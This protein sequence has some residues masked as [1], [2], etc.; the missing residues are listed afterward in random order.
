MTEY[1][2]EPG[3]VKIHSLPFPVAP[4]DNGRQRGNDMD[5]RKQELLSLWEEFLEISN[6]RNKY[7]EECYE[8]HLSA[9][10]NFHVYTRR[11]DLQDDDEL[12]ILR[13]FDISWD[14]ARKDWNKR[15]FVQGEEATAILNKLNQTED[16]LMETIAKNQETIEK[17]LEALQCS[18]ND[19]KEA[20]EFLREGKKK[21]AETIETK[22]K[23]K[24]LFLDTLTALHK[25]EKIS[26]ENQ[27]PPREFVREYFKILLQ[28]LKENGFLI[29]MFMFCD[30][31]DDEFSS[32]VKGTI[33]AYQDKI[34][35]DRV[36]G[37]TKPI[38]PLLRQ[39][40]RPADLQLYLSIVSEKRKKPAI[41]ILELIDL[42]GKAK[43]K[44]EV[45]EL[46]KVRNDLKS[47][48]GTAVTH[49]KQRRADLEISLLTVKRAFRRHIKTANN[50][51][52]YVEF[53]VFPMIPKS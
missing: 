52:R 5:D 32:E 2:S 29:L 44:K 7:G 33:K 36:N 13:I 39:G 12:S 28:S 18:K 43:E 3:D 23:A 26:P 11:F 48:T 14:M 34:I 22:N 50:I 6:Y 38:L 15:E 4:V 49:L 47:A 37:R 40:G 1:G 51:L 46:R 53:G 42:F 35:E 30:Y 25:A 9:I 17:I 16:L 24:G 20:M 27:D 45:R 41:T 21:Q 31:V 10:R 8:K 19:K